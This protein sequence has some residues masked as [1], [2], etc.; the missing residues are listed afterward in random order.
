MNI[1]QCFTR[2]D[3]RP[4]TS[5]DS[6]ETYRDPRNK[7]KMISIDKRSYP[8]DKMWYVHPIGIS[9]E[10]PSVDIICPYCGEIHRHGNAEGHR[11]SHCCS[12]DNPG[13]IIVMGGQHYEK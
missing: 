5:I 2:K 3:I 9:A 1:K 13:Y 4:V 11:V 8:K 6:I 10:G 12:N 7:R